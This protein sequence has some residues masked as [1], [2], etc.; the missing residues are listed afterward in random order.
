[1]R[2]IELVSGELKGCALAVDNLTGVKKSL[3]ILDSHR[4]L[5]YLKLLGR[6]GL[7]ARVTAELSRNF[8]MSGGQIENVTRKY[9]INKV[10][11][12]DDISYETLSS[13]CKEEQLVKQVHNTVGFKQIDKNR[14]S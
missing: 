13:Y 14:A 10:L 9:L 12:G 8:A 3:D 2:H 7:T 1:M 5:T 4:E 6:H 11:Y